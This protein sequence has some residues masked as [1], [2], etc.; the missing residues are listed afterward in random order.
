MKMIDIYDRLYDITSENMSKTGKTI[1]MYKE[2][3]LFKQ[4]SEKGIFDVSLCGDCE[5]EVFLQ[6]VYVGML[7]RMPDPG[8]VKAWREKLSLPK[9]EFRRQMI[10]KISLSE[11]FAKKDV[12]IINNVFNPTL[13]NDSKTVWQYSRT[14]RKVKR[15]I[16]SMVKRGYIR[17]PEKCKATIK[18]AVKR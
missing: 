6:M 10:E 5:N 17:L 2:T 15:K 18:R 8:A 13:L 7:E 11:E 1:A 16:Y 4:R 9:S 14:M 3:F 12:K